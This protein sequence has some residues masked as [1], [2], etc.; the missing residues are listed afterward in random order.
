MRFLIFLAQNMNKAK[1]TGVGSSSFRKEGG[2]GG[3]GPKPL[4]GK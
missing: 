4:L 1:T 3:V 2:G